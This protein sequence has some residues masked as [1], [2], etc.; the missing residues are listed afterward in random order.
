[1]IAYAGVL[2]LGIFTGAF[3]QWCLERMRE[4]DEA[5]EE[6][7]RQWV[8]THAVDRWEKMMDDY[9]EAERVSRRIDDVLASGGHRPG[10]S[11]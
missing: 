1:M 6:W 10:R 3:L 9:E 8:G 11:A 2:V 4:N 5:T 7:T